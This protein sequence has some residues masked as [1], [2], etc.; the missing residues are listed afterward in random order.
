MGCMGKAI[1]C[2]KC[3]KLLCSTCS[4]KHPLIPFDTSNPVESNDL[5]RNNQIH[6]YCKKCFQ[7][8][9]VLDFATHDEEI[10]PAS[11]QEQEQEAQTLATT[12]TTFVFV[13]GGGSSRAMYRGHANLLS[14]RGY[15]CIL[16]DLPGHGTMV[17]TPLTLDSCVDTVKSVLEK[18]GLLKD[19]PGQKTIYVGGSFGAYTGFYV[20]DKLQDNF[21]GAVQMDCGQN[22]GPGASIKARVGMWFLKKLANHLSNTALMKSMLDVSRKS[23]ADY[24]LVETTFGAGFYFDQGVAQTECL[25][26]VAPASHIPHLKFPILFMNGSE[27]HRDSEEKWLSLCQDQQHSKLKVF[28]G[29]DHFFCHDTRFLTEIIDMMDD[30]AKSI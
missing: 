27:D 5:S 3:N 9:S 26:S 16:L 8:R 6:I 17:E 25:Q 12:T 20:L 30:F 22:V 15:R 28:E 1:P 7:E 11:E 23:P 18:Y 21:S 4:G 19:T 14:E 10:V 13:H 24:K 29:G 2:S